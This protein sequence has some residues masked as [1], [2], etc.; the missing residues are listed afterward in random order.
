MPAGYLLPGTAASLRNGP[1][2]LGQH[3]L[4]GWGLATAQ[5]ADQVRK[6]QPDGVLFLSPL[7]SLLWL[8][9]EKGKITERGAGKFGLTLFKETMPRK[10][11]VVNQPVDEAEERLGSGK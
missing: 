10:L 2:Q 11:F 6:D 8:P 5:T 1:S 3:L 4:E 7:S 9:K